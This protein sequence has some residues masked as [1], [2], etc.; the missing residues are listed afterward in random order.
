[1]GSTSDLK[2][3][4]EATK[5]FDELEIPYNVQVISSHRT[6]HHLYKYASEVANS[7]IEVIIAGAGMAASLPGMLAAL[8][9]LPVIGV[10]L[11]SGPLNG[12]DALFSISQMPKGI[13]TATMAINGAANA[14]LFAAAILA[15]KYPD[16]HE[17]LVNWREAQT[18]AATHLNNLH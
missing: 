18:I 2:T 14:A 5:I 6:P 8:S 10:P 4:Q 9:V 12:L 17:S 13:P 1:M 15:L 3:M 16:I 7:G 11:S